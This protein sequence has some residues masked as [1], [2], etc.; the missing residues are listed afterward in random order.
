VLYNDIKMK[1]DTLF[2]TFFKKFPS[3]FFELIERSAEDAQHYQFY[4][5][6]MKQAAFRMDGV[7]LP[8]E[9]TDHNPIYFVEVQFQKDPW[10][11]A[12]MLC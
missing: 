9:D 10:F 12:R 8:Q 3:L 4:V 7:F 6:E 1:T 11:Y 5:P 2:Y